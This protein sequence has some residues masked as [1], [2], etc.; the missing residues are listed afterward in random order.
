[1]FYLKYRPK[2]IQ[3]IDN[4]HIREVVVNILKSKDLPHALLFIGQKGTGKTSTARIFAKT[5]NCLKNK[6]S[7]SSSSSIEPC[8]KCS[9][10]KN[11]DTS[12]SPDVIEMDAASNRGID[13]VRNLIKEANFV[14]MTTRFRVFI[15]DEAH[16]ITTDAFNALLKTLEEPPSSVIFILA[17][18]NSEKIPKTISSRCT[19]INFGKAHLVDIIHMLKRYAKAENLKI[20]EKLSMLIAQYS[21]HSFRDAAKILEEL[22]VQNKLSYEDTKSF[23]G[24]YRQNLIEILAE[25]DL[26]Q[27]LQ[28]IEEF[29]QKGG[30]F[31]HLIERLLD[32]LRLALLKKNGVVTENGMDFKLTI[33]EIMKLMKLFTEAYEYLKYTPVES[34]PLEIAVVEFY[35]FSKRKS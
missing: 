35:N 12:S 23:L 32:D 16:M 13:D 8:N 34:I 15:I 9:N 5:V 11:I 17:T 19:I 22:V 2:T 27:S 21:D 29:S 6:F 4:S 7:S 31:K 18:T 14:P 28:W 24:V 10:C 26:T 25:K 3:E 1:M 20:D 33:N 30:D